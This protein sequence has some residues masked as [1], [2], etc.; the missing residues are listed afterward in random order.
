[1][2]RNKSGS[3]SAGLDTESRAEL[4]AN[5]TLDSFAP[6]FGRE[7]G[8][9]EM[10]STVEYEA[11][12]DVGVIRLRRPEVLNAL[13]RATLAAFLS[14]AETAAED[15]DVGAIVVTGGEQA[16][17]TGE[18]LREAAQLSVADFSRQIDDI[19]R[20]ASVLRDAPKPVVAAIGGAAYGGGLEIAVNCDLRV[21]GQNARFACPEVNWGLTITNGASVLLRRLVGDGWTRELTL[22]GTVVDAETAAKIGLVTRVVRPRDLETTAVELARRGASYAVDAVR[23]TKALL[24]ADGQEWQVIL[25]ADAAA[26]VSGFGSDVTRERLAAFAARKNGSDGRDPAS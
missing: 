26:V 8:A 17:C 9:R 11:D 2:V 15:P 7:T 19:Q 23:A 22:F 4:T 25:D 6:S 1:V 14:A 5:R 10:N 16:F 13:D 18:D 24:N 20:L 3:R 12:G 21:A